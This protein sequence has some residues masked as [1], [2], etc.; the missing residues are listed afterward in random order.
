MKFGLTTAQIKILTDLFDEHL[1]RG[2]VI[3][4]GSRAK[5]NYKP[6]SDIDLVLQSAVPDDRLLCAK[7]KGDIDESNFPYLCD[8]QFYEEIKSAE[9]LD[10]IKRVGKTIFE[11]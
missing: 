1:E 9:L 6:Y 3:V 7:I 8:L 4:Y 5:G 11:K 10:H 2:R